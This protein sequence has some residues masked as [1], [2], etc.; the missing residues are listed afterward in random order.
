MAKAFSVLSWN[1]EHFKNSPARVTEVVQLLAQINPD[2]FAIYEVEGREVD[3]DLVA[4]MPGY[5]FHITEG[6]QVQEI[7][8]GVRGGMTAF[9][10]QKIEFRSG[11]SAMRP[12]PC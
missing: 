6:P 5:Q 10:T 12:G 9:F 11:A 1:I 3:A 4:K 8:V 7:L 2:V